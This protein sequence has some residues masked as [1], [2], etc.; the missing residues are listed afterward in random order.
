MVSGGGCGWLVPNH[1]AYSKAWISPLLAGVQLH[2]PLFGKFPREESRVPS[3]IHR[4]CSS[5]PWNMTSEEQK[6]I[7]EAVQETAGE[8]LGIDRWDRPAIFRESA[9][10]ATDNGL[11]YWAVLMLSGAI[12]TLGLALN[13][14][15][16]VIGA[17]LV[18]PLLAP[19]VGLALALA[20]GDGRLAIQSGAVV[21]GSTVAVVLTGAFLTAVLPFQTVTL[22]I[23]AR[24]R[25]TTL[26]LVIAIFSG[27]VGAV[28]TVA[29]G[30]RLSAAIPGVA[31][32]VALIPPLAVA[33][34]GVAADWNASLI[35]GSLLLY[36]ANLAG[37]VLSGMGVFLLVGMHRPEVVEAALRWHHRGSP[38]GLAA[39]ADRFRWVR[40]LEILRSAWARVGLVMAF[41]VAV[42]IPL[43]ETLAQIAREARV[44]RAVGRADEQF[45]V[46][47]RTSILSREIVYGPDQT[48]VYLRIATTR[49]FG[50]DARDEFERIAGAAAGEPVRLA[51]EQLPASGGDI[52]EFAKLLPS[53]TP[54]AQSRPTPARLTDLLSLA[55]TRLDEVAGILALPDGIAVAGLELATTRYGRAITRVV[56]ASESRLPQE[57]E[58]MLAKQLQGALDIPELQVRLTHVSTAPR[59]LD[60][61]AD[62][63]RFQE[64]AA[65]LRDN[66]GL[67]VEV[68]APSAADSASIAQTVES[69]NRLGV[70]R[71]RITTQREAEPG[72]RLRLR[73]IS[74]G[75]GSPSASEEALP[76]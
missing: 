2:H 64:V 72:L 17:M 45:E 8:K 9:E 26:D 74:S 21:L 62:T 40:R 6:P 60:A 73:P 39:L 23:S 66:E 63:V 22:E 38:H 1:H 12:A 51:L 35:R 48:Q 15:A 34:F 43:S 31:I 16:V 44:Q 53:Q 4:C 25:P 50:P 36:G 70:E 61:L 54:A 46:P 18:A 20:V 52:E 11:P 33:G 58:Q 68:V 69:L 29:R 37:I 14:S 10:A 24:A 28:V 30:S 56:Y 3:S 71:G 27:L 76:R 13:S 32:S 75:Q 55:R 5:T 49:W 59:P 57:A 65:L 7:A 41:A 42:G 67:R 19:V 47:G